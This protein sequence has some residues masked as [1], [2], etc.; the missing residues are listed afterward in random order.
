MGVLHEAKLLL[1][2]VSRV[3]FAIISVQIISFKKQAAKSI[4]QDIMRKIIEN[5]ER[6]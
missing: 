6:K 1:G 4:F 5:T 2:P 3:L